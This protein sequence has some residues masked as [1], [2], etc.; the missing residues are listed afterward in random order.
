VHRAGSALASVTAL[1][2]AGDVEPFALRV[3]EGDA[4]FDVEP[5]GAAVDFDGDVHSISFPTREMMNRILIRYCD[6]GYRIIIRYATRPL[7]LE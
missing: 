7:S 2:G 6:R 1:L 4:G 5:L 3:Q